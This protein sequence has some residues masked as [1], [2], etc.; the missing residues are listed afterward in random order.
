ML[1]AAG[2]LLLAGCQTAPPAVNDPRVLA[3]LP[4][5]ADAYF[6][7]D[8]RNNH[9]LA[10]DFISAVSAGAARRGESNSAVDRTR[11]VYGALARGKL[12]IVGSGQYPGFLFSYAFRGN[13]NWNEESIRVNGKKLSYWQQ[14]D[15]EF[16][17]ALSRN[18]TLLASNGDIQSLFSREQQ[19]AGEIPAVPPE[20]V[21]EFGLQDLVFYAPGGEGGSF[22]PGL[23]SGVVGHLLV[24]VRG[25]RPSGGAAQAASSYA[26]SFSLTARS[27]R[28]ARTVSVLLRL[29]MV[30]LLSGSGSDGGQSPV[31]L[32]KN[33]HVGV[34]GK[35]V[36]VSGITLSSDEL[37]SLIFQFRGASGIK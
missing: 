34:K 10:Q 19:S 33:L 3:L 2:S 37:S 25:N 8:V 12:Y 20:V 11:Y 28:D 30:S 9:V 36:N 13:R 18:G 24:L 15:G 5:G 17:V 14:K 22:L 16:Q 32:M 6:F 27:E 35:T 26:M 7:L 1:V 21:Q 29:G 31:E 4:P 23:A